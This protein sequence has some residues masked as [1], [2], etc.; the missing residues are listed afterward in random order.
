MAKNH[1]KLKTSLVKALQIKITCYSI[2]DP[3]DLLILERLTIPSVFKEVVLVHM[4]YY[5]KCHKYKV[6]H[7][8]QTFTSHSSGG[9]E[10]QDEGISTVTFW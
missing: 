3:P 10:F 2:I 7:K 6:T 8:L 9:W 5:K 1:E 4:G